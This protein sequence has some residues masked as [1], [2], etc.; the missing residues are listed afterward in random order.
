VA[1]KLVCILTDLCP[2][3]YEC[4]GSHSVTG[5]SVAFLWRVS[6]QIV[7]TICL[8]WCSEFYR[9]AASPLYHHDVS[10]VMEIY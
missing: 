8:R 3:Q 10:V 2:L 7:F 9:C 6:Q 5:R 1:N 4:T